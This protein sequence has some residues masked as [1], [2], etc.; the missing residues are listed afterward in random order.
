MSIE[1]KILDIML[2]RE[3]TEEESREFSRELCE[4][5]WSF[6]ETKCDLMILLY[7]YKRVSISL[8]ALTDKRQIKYPQV[9]E[10]MLKKKEIKRHSDSSYELMPKGVRWMHRNQSSLTKFA[11]KI[12]TNEKLLEDKI[13]AKR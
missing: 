6:K 7:Q 5:E 10:G 9:I 4:M 11:E 1:P 3:L 8:I 12:A 2:T 13:K